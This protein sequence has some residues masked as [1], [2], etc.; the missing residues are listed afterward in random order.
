M[1]YIDK[2]KVFYPLETWKDNKILRAWW[3]KVTKFDDD[4]EE[5]SEILMDKYLGLGGNK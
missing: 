3:E 1:R 2:L 5:F 4:L